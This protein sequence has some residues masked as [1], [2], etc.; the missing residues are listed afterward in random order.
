MAP[1]ILDPCLRGVR[2]GLRCLWTF[3]VW[4]VWLGLVLLLAGQAYIATQNQLELP[5]FLLRA[6]E[7]RLAVSG[8]TVKFGRALFDPSGRVLIEA[9]RIRLD[10]FAEPVATARTIYL[11][12]DPWALVAGRFEPTELRATGVEL[13]V[14]A[15]LS[16][17]GRPEELV[18]DLDVGLKLGRKLVTV[19]YLNFRLAGIAVSGRGALEVSSPSGVAPAAGALA[20]AEFFARNYGLLSKEFAQA[21]A[22]LSALDQPV[23]RAV[24]SPSPTRGAIVAVTVVAQGL[25]W[26]G[27]Q[28]G[29]IRAAGQVPLLGG[30]A[31]VT[32][33]HLEA[34]GVRLANGVNASG[35]VVDVTGSLKLDAPAFQPERL[36]L[37]ARS[38]DWRG[39]NAQ[40]LLARVELGW[41]ARFTGEILAQLM[42]QPVDLD[43]AVD[44]A[45]RTAQ[46]RFDAALAPELLGPAS[47]WLQTDLRRYA[48]LT[49]PLHT[50][51]Q[52]RFTPGWHFAG[53]STWLVGND[54]RRLGLTVDH[55][56]ARVEL[57]PDRLWSP[58]AFARIGHNFA[59][60]SYEQ[61]LA[62][63]DFRFL[64][65][66]EVRPLELSD[67][68]G[69]WWPRFFADYGFPVAPVEAS[70]DL[71]GRWGDDPR[72]SQFVAADVAGMTLRGVSFDWL[73]TRMFV[74]P[75]WYDAL[76]ISAGQGP[77][78]A[79]GRFLIRAETEHGVITGLD[80]AG[81]SSLDLANAGR[82]I[83]PDVGDVVQPF[84]FAQPP[85]IVLQGHFDGPAAPAPLHQ[86][87]HVEAHTER[88]MT[89]QGIDF[90]RA[91]F[92]V[93]L[94][95][96]TLAISQIDAGFAGGSLTG[97]ATLRGSGA[98]RK[99]AFAGTMNHATLGP[100]AAAAA[101][102]SSSSGPPSSWQTLARE[103]SGVRVDLSLSAEGLY[104]DPYSFHG[105]GRVVLQGAELGGIS[106]LGGLSRL[107][108][109]TALRFTTAQTDFK[110]DGAR[111]DFPDLTITG[112]N[113]AIRAHGTYQF[114]RRQL[115]FSAKV[116]PFQESKSILQVFNVLSTPLSAV[117]Q[118]R[119]SGSI[120]RPAWAFTYGPLNLLRGA[121]GGASTSPASGAPS[122]LAHPAP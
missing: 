77:G 36:R 26:T 115:D 84:H 55:L 66:G 94:Q 21:V 17:S 120:D 117:L 95:D 108:R 38:A 104:G 45:Q 114:E 101:G 32:T 103:K 90:E 20:P 113:S 106:L 93:D 54:L 14:P 118:V 1:G 100:T 24:L 34:D 81:T 28:T 49:Q 33:F 97:Q 80:V 16:A 107:L 119:L 102:F 111:L 57:T 87:L 46:V 10:S 4:S 40:S 6:F 18:R 23:V 11:R 112:A 96:D 88:T 9:A 15:M 7:Q 61:N 122:P 2:L 58:E 37:T 22:G 76:D 72:S 13:L 60:G 50:T 63:K 105:E 41:P 65:K 70:V 83:G 67:W 73:R 75:G 71:Q 68:F 116:Y 3:A 86:Q 69:P 31:T 56:E 99:L 110:V 12:L 53:L 30:G 19:D 98:G 47:R 35:L 92:V 51:G 78:E 5:P 52:V 44:L 62:T 42:G 39:V 64:L 25:K 91:A 48:E 8:V 89:F 43:G 121:G 79:R 82:L 109:V 59:R 29:P 74:R 85:A 27:G